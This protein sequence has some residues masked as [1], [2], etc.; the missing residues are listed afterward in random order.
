MTDTQ[1]RF[2]ILKAIYNEMKANPEGY[3]LFIDE[4]SKLAGPDYKFNLRYLIE[5]GWIKN[6]FGYLTLTAEGIDEVEKI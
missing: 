4:L 6:S 5:K 1:V 3:G 2:K